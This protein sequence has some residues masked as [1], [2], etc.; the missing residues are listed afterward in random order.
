MHR[1]KCK[2]I[3]Q[4]SAKVH[5]LKPFGYPEFLNLMANAKVVLTDSG[6]IQEET[7]VLGIPCITLRDTTERPITL[8]QGTNV[9]ARNDPQEIIR[10]TAKILEGKE[11][12]GNRP[13]FWHGHTAERIVRILVIRN[14]KEL[15]GKVL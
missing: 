7:T 13:P 8:T 11:R 10:E 1:I 5:C 6:G 3:L 12:K 14:S 2:K 9:L 4:S 15:R